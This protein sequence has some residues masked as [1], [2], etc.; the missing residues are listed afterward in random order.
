MA[1]RPLPPIEQLRQLLR[2]D[3]ATGKLFWKNRSAPKP[4]EARAIASWNA[5]FAGKEA[6]TSTSARGYLRGCIAGLP[7]PAHRVVWTLYYGEEPSGVIDHIDGD[8]LHNRIDNLRAVSQ[9]TNMRNQRIRSNNTS[10]C[11]GVTQKGGR[12]QAR[13]QTDAGRK[14]LGLFASKEEAIAARRFAEAAARYHPN[15][16]RESEAA[17]DA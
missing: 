5:R 8:Q 13:I 10:G 15:H 4:S 3:C 7:Y 6:F 2:L 1:A 12:W 11:M 14:Y 16:G 17:N 9:R